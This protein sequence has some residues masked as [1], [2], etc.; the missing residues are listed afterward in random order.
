[1]ASP[2]FEAAL[3]NPGFRQAGAKHQP[4][5][6]MNKYNPDPSILRVKKP[7]KT[8]GL[9]MTPL[10]QCHEESWHSKVFGTDD[11]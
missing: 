11:I 7:R 5:L 2:I 1:M 3:A 9:A 6:K 10:T 8:K 4:T